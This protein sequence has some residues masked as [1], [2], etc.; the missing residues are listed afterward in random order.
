M[1]VI[2]IRAP[3]PVSPASLTIPFSSS[4]ISGEKISIVQLSIFS[5]LKKGIYL[6][7]LRNSIR[8]GK[9]D[10]KIKNADCAA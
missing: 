1:V 4:P 6:S 9:I 10:I 8:N 5:P 7:K 2:E 3:E